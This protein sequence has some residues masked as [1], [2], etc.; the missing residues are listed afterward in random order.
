VEARKSQAYTRK[1]KNI[2]MSSSKMTGLD[3]QE[4]KINIRKKKTW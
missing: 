4:N 3:K 1:K 2:Y